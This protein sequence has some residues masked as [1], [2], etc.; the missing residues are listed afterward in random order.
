MS[1]LLRVWALV[2]DPP[3][4]LGWPQPHANSSQQMAQGAEEATSPTL[5]TQPSVWGWT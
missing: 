4:V 3:L 1:G 5:D 2:K